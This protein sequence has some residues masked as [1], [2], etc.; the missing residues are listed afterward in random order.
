MAR[1]GAQMM[2]IKER[3]GALLAFVVLALAAV[4]IGTGAASAS[5]LTPPTGLTASAAYPGSVDLSWQPVPGATFYTYSWSQT[6]GG[7]FAY[8]DTTSTTS[9]TV[10]GLDP[11][12]SYDFTVASGTG[13][14]SAAVS[15]TP[16]ADP[17]PATALSGS[18]VG[19]AIRL[20]WTAPA[21]AG[22]STLTGYSAICATPDG[23]SASTSALPSATSAD[24][25]GLPVGGYW[26]CSLTAD[27]ADTATSVVQ[28]SQQGQDIAPL[29]VRDLTG[30]PT[31]TGI[32]VSWEPSLAD[33]SSVGP[34]GP[35]ANVVSAYGCGM[36]V[37]NEPIGGPH[38]GGEIDTVTL[39][40]PQASCPVT[41]VVVGHGS[42][43]PVS[44]QVTSGDRIPAGVANLRAAQ[45]PGQVSLSWGAPGDPLDGRS[46]VSGYAVSVTSTVVRAGHT[47]TLV[48]ETRAAATSDVID[49]P[50]GAT[51]MSLT[52]AAVNAAGTG[53]LASAGVSPPG[54]SVR[55]RVTTKGGRAIVVS[56]AKLCSESKGSCPP[57]TGS[58]L[59]DHVVRIWH[60]VGTRW[61]SLG[62]KTTQ[63]GAV[64]FRL[65]GAG[66][67][68]IGTGNTVGTV[69]V[70]R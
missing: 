7:G 29:P 1:L 31:A 10:W 5:G 15:A 14:A 38:A 53:P 46:S 41:V 11:A 57:A 54:V 30:Q 68:G 35:A 17:D 28:L 24:V 67:Y 16:Y 4:T 12:H 37:S 65:G 18:V 48:F 6:G 42:A 49:I 23:A 22:G 52:V 25:T 69:V 19:A 40:V 44:A 36:D 59:A 32:V 66:R 9:A 27:F 63:N 62:H 21:S 39:A 60:R 50:I 64:T 13:A 3:T 26:Y 70:V 43:M 47:S 2:L 58:G 45:G 56:F 8:S 34:F 51:A 33:G 55:T 20:T 61:V